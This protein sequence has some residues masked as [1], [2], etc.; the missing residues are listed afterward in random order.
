MLSQPILETDR[1]ILRPLNSADA[2]SI[3]EKAS[4]RAIADTTI[5]IPHPYPSGEA[6]RYIARQ[7][8]ARK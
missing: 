5:S 1:L 2:P 6:E 4:A 3:Q 8:D 7:L